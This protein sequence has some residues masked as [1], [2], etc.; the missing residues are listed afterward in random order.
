MSEQERY[1]RLKAYCGKH[2][3]C[4]SCLR[5]LVKNVEHGDCLIRQQMRA[6]MEKERA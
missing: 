6:E 5:G 1:K 3:S 2:R 4:R